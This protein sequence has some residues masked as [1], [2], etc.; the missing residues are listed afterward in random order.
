MTGPAAF[1]FPAPIWLLLRADGREEGGLQIHSVSHIAIGV[2]DMEKALAFYRDVLGM[3]VTLD[4]PEEFPGIGGA[5]PLRRRGVYLRWGEGAH[6]SFVVLDEQQSTPP[7]GEPARLFQ[8]GVDRYEEIINTRGNTQH[9]C[10]KDG[11]AWAGV[12][13]CHAHPGEH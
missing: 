2:R 4:I 9:R 6:E 8:V 12:S 3:R 7:F 11:H 5:D 1:E 10:E 13:G